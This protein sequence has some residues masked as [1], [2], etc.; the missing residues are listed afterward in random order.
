MDPLLERFMRPLYLY[1]LKVSASAVSL[2][3]GYPFLVLTEVSGCEPLAKSFCKP[4]L[5]QG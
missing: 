2:E 1:L 3:E 4:I 5:A